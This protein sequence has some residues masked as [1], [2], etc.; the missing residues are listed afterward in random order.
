VEDL[1]AD[2]AGVFSAYL[3]ILYDSTLVTT[4][5]PVEF[6]GPYQDGTSGETSVPG[7]LNEV[8]AF[9]G[10]TPLGAGEALLFRVPVMATAPGTVDFHPN[11]AEGFDHGVLLYLESAPLPPL[12]VDFAGTSIDILPGSPWQNPAERTDVSG[13]GPTT[14]LDALLLINEKEIPRY[15]DPNTGELPS[16]RPAYAPYLDVDGHVGFS[17]FDLVIVINRLNPSTIRSASVMLCTATH[18]AC[19]ACKA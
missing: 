6:V 4:S 18:V 11:P 5:G 12:A 3:D 2:A 14:P 7:L 13:E 16:P 10:D 8:G 19:R 17:L 9:D 1:R 15:H